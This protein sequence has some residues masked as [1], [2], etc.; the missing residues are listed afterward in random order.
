MDLQEAIKRERW[1]HALAPSSI[2]MI[3]ERFIPNHSDIEKILI[4]IT[5][6]HNASLEQIAESISS[7]PTKPA[8][9]AYIPYNNDNNDSKGLA[10]RYASAIARRQMLSMQNTFGKTIEEIGLMVHDLGQA[11]SAEMRLYRELRLSIEKTASEDNEESLRKYGPPHS[12][13]PP[14]FRTFPFLRT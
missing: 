13:V 7:V 10:E 3:L 1:S 12:Y 8:V 5:R 6:E 14:S 4:A 9:P 11:S 2:L